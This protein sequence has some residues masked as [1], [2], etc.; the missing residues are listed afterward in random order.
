MWICLK[1]LNERTPKTYTIYYP[2]TVTANQG[3][4]TLKSSGEA[5]KGLP[6]IGGA[7][8]NHQPQQQQQQQQAS[9]SVNSIVQTTKP[10]AK[11]TNN[12]EKLKRGLTNFMNQLN[13]ASFFVPAAVQPVPQLQQASKGELGAAKQLNA[14][15]TG[16][17]TSAETAAI[18]NGDPT[19]D[20]LIK[21][22]NR[23]SQTRPIGGPLRWG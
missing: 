11:P 10:S 15:K 8:I 21:G 2:I 7:Q 16:S 23:L 18:V 20:V 5:P 13:P 1:F 17:Q 12:A 6:I 19:A 22:P 4:E 9:A 3:K 14:S